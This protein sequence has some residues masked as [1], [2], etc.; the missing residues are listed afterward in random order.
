[1][2]FPL[3]I[4]VLEVVFESNS[5]RPS[6]SSSTHPLDHPVRWRAIESVHL[7][8]KHPRATTISLSQFLVLAYL[9]TVVAA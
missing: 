9:V 2:L 3:Y 4:L 5:V 6:G 7:V 8:R 1:M